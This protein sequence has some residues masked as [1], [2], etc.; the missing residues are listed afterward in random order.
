[1]RIINANIVL[2][3]KVVKGYV[4]F[5]QNKIIKVES[6]KSK[7]AG[8]DAKGLYLLPTFFDSHTH[9]GYGVDFNS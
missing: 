3:N 1:M 4:E 2:E 8:Y 5:D 6:G 7:Q 9:G